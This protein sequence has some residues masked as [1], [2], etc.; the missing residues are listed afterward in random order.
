MKPLCTNIHNFV[1]VLLLVTPV[2]GGKFPGALPTR[3]V[4]MHYKWHCFM[5][6]SV[7]GLCILELCLY[8]PIVEVMVAMVLDDVAFDEQS[9]VTRNTCVHYTCTVN[10]SLFAF[11]TLTFNLDNY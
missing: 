3:F 2:F 10:R 1:A 7:S 9:I 5:I 11:V 8:V 6:Y 4:H